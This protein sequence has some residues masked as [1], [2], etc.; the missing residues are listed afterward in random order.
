VGKLRRTALLNYFGG[1]QEIQKANR[2]EIAKV[3]GISLALADKIVE[4]LRR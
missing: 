1:F 3:D 4:K 2:D